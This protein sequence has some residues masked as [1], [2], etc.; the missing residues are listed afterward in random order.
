MATQ[1]KQVISKIRQQNPTVDELAEIRK[2]LRSQLI[3]RAAREIGAKPV[4]R[5]AYVYRQG[6]ETRE[7][8]SLPDHLLPPNVKR[9]RRGVY[10]IDVIRGRVQRPLEVRNPIHVPLKVGVKK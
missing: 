9:I 8:D 6:D 4:Q 7:W 2:V 3:D 5:P 10:N 1:L